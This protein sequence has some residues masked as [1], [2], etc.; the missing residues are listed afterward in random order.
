[1][2]TDHLLYMIQTKFG[3]ESNNSSV[4]FIFKKDFGHKLFITIWSYIVHIY[5]VPCKIWHTHTRTRLQ[6][7]ACKD[8]ALTL[9][10]THDIKCSFQF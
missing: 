6:Y 4:V 5:V 7:C 10:H 1:M 3:K 8:H 2:S 9:N